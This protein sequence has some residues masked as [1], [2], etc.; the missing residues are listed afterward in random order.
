MK[1]IGLTT[2]ASAL[3]KIVRYV[4]QEQPAPCVGPKLPASEGSVTENEVF[5]FSINVTNYF[6]DIPW[7]VLMLHRRLCSLEPQDRSFDGLGSPFSTI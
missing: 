6:L 5:L 2:E 7:D 1:R 3:V 4:V